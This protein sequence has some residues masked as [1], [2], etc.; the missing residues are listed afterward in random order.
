MKKIYILFF[1]VLFAGSAMA[2]YIAE[3]AAASREAITQ[4]AK[5]DA[6]EQ[7][8]ASSS[9]STIWT[10]TFEDCSDWEINNA[11]N[12][13]FTQ[14]VQGLDW[15]CGVGLAPTGPAAIAPINSTTA[16]NGFMMVDSDE[17]GG[18]EG[19][20][21]VENC[22]FQ[23]VE[24]IDCSDFPAVSIS[25][26]NQYFKWDG[27]NDDGNEKCL[28]EVSRDGVTW[29]SVE[30]WDESNGFV[31][32]DGEMV[33]ARWE[34]FPN[35]GTQDPFTNPTL[36]VF[37]ISEI[38]GG[39]ETVYLRFRWKGTW[40]YAWMV[41]D[42]TVYE[43]PE[44]DIAIDSYVSLTDYETT[45]MYEYGVWPFSQL[46]ELQMAASVRN[47]GQNLAENVTLSATVNG[48][49]AGGTALP[50]DIASAAVDTARLVGFTPPAVEGTYNVEMTIS[51]DAE[52]ENAD[53]DNANASFEVTEFLYGRDNGVYSSGFPATTYNQE[54][55]FANGYQFFNET[56]IYAIDVMMIAGENGADI[57]AHVLDGGLDIVASSEEFIMSPA[58]I[59]N[60]PD[61]GNILWTTIRLS[62][63]YTVPAN[64]FFLASI[65]N[66]GGQGVR[67]GRS[68][69]AP[70]QTC[71]VYGFF[72]TQGALDWYFTTTT[73]MLRF[74]LDPDAQTGVQ[75]VVARNNF[76]LFQNMPNPANAT[77]RIRYELA[78]ND[79]VSFEV[80]DLTGKRVKADDF[81]MQVAGEHQ[82]DLNIADLAPG[83]YTYTLTVGNERATRKMI[84]Q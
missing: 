7:N 63:P 32:Y 42:V 31:D 62:Q 46:T 28:L 84:V 79:R 30:T 59:D 16:D 23:T 56:T 38:A 36:V 21:G 13:G 41:D 54:F 58:V 82:F 11:Y 4:R 77:T 15:L 70:A 71:F 75:E 43:T 48:T 44:N 39:Q 51:M 74:N 66:F 9:R 83:L 78:Q 34:C 24:S 55:S 22:W 40:G 50:I 10:N 6:P 27:G 53:N 45:E 76:L 81:G 49:D 64:S 2:Q 68:V 61:D 65:Q 12:E 29:P 5:I 33:Q 57:Q 1:S 37:E 67:L 80:M 18:E 25:F 35:V 19:G 60:T 14:F 72:G 20:S 47:L 17:F 8:L 69:P 73:G 26:E 3:P 52:D